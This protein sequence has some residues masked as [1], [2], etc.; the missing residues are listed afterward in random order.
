MPTDGRYPAGTGCTG[1]DMLKSRARVPDTQDR[2]CLGTNHSLEKRSHKEADAPCN[3]APNEHKNS[4]EPKHIG[5]KGRL[6]IYGLHKRE[7]GSISTS[8]QYNTYISVHAT[9]KMISRQSQAQ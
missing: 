3:K 5:R 8:S 7:S 9:Y 2:V 4:Q 6:R 1:A